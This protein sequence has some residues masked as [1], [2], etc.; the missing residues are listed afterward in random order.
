MFISQSFAV[1]CNQI[2]VAYV[3]LDS[4]NMAFKIRCTI[5]EPMYDS[6]YVWIFFFDDLNFLQEKHLKKI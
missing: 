1:W 4:F 2:G 3:V 5:L 6:E